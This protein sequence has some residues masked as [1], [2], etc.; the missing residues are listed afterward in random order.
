MARRRCALACSDASPVMK[1][2][3]WT[4]QSWVSCLELEEILKPLGITCRMSRS[5]LAIGSAVPAARSFPSD[6]AQSAGGASS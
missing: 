4:V 1:Q 5:M 3:N 2:A 6:E